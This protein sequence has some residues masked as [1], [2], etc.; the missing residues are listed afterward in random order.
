MCEVAVQCDQERTDQMRPDA[1]LW[2]VSRGQRGRAWLRARGGHARVCIWRRRQLRHAGVVVGCVV[3]NHMQAALFRKSCALRSAAG[4]RIAACGAGGLEGPGAGP[5]A[6]KHDSS[7]D[8]SMR[9]HA[10]RW[11]G[12][13]EC[14]RAEE[15]RAQTRAEMRAGGR[16][17]RQ[18][19]AA[20]APPH[21]GARAAPRTLGRRRSKSAIPTLP[22]GSSLAGHKRPPR[23]SFGGASESRGPGRPHAGH[24]PLV[25][26]SAPSST[27]KTTG[28]VA[29][30]VRFAAHSPQWQPSRAQAVRADPSR[31]A[32]H[33]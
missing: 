5:R 10:S 11:R 9:T 1:A 13:Q 17:P 25:H 29:H 15:C 30:E 7:N 20:V 12:V 22:P 18:R 27:K 32:R 21:P 19:T 33:S 3:W 26:A 14:S 16:L 6:R 23:P 31:A 28:E 2:V 4:A 24:V 8:S